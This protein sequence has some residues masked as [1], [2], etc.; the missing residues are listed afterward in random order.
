MS[1]VSGKFVLRIPSSLHQSL[2]SESKKKGLSLNQYCLEILQSR[3]KCNTKALQQHLPHANKIISKLK[4]KL[5]DSFLGIVMFGSRAL[6]EHTE[7]SDL[8]LL[9]VLKASASLDRS[10]YRWWDDQ[11]FDLSYPINPHF[12]TLPS[13]TSQIGSLWLEAASSGKLILDTNNKIS[14]FF[15]KIHQAIDEGLVQR[16]WSHGHPYWIWKNHEKQIAH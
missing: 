7:D 2:S 14:A 10:L 3:F 13:D 9:I 4:K 16:S 8:D 5:G 6:E 12:V 1:S 11:S 15:K